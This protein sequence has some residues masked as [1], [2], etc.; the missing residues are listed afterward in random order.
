MHGKDFT[1]THGLTGSR[2]RSRAQGWRLEARLPSQNLRASSPHGAGA[3]LGA[4]PSA[5]GGCHSG[6]TAAG[7]DILL[8]LLSY[9]ALPCTPF[10]ASLL[11]GPAPSIITSL[12]NLQSLL[13]QRC[14]LSLQTSVN[15]RPEGR[16]RPRFCAPS[17]HCSGCA[18]RH[19]R[20]LPP[21][22]SAS[23][24][25]SPEFSGNSTLIFPWGPPPA[26]HSD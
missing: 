11:G 15:L 14:P 23:N 12:Q 18:H 9:G 13:P 3:V 19:L 22:S 21:A 5:I 24:S 2:S 8:F 4:M 7:T 1:S 26:G 25:S 6:K 17:T 16:G 20:P 10:S